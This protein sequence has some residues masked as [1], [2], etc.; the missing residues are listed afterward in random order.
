M[1]AE[2]S[3]QKA[4]FSESQK[5][6]ETEL[7]I[8]KD[9]LSKAYRIEHLIKCVYHNDAYVL[10]VK[11]EDGFSVELINNGM[12][13]VLNPDG[14][15]VLVE[16]DIEYATFDSA[17]EAFDFYTENIKGYQEVKS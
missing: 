3:N 7:K 6:L 13:Y 1:R 15:F 12:R 14:K 2:L 9:F 16:M 10:V 4:I 5:E 11:E 8:H 17:K